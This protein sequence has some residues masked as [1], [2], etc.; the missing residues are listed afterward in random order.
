VTPTM[1]DTNVLSELVRPRPD[2]RVER[3]VGQC[4]NPIVSSAIFHE[5]A[6]GIRL[7]PNSTRKSQVQEFFDSVRRRFVG[8]VVDID[9]GIAEMS[10]NLRGSAY[11]RGEVL[12]EMDSL[13]AACAIARS[14]TLA[15]RNV[16][17]FEKLGIPLV[18]PWTN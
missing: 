9:A 18:N 6:F 1:M 13:I 8:R 2:P 5:I 11:R 14:A 10:G 12:T 16:R 17:D 3:F 7:M 4:M 15:T